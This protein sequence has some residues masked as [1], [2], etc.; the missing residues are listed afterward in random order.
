VTCVLG[1]VVDGP[2]I[3][4]DGLLLGAVRDAANVV[5]LAA[6]RSASA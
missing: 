5:D 3:I 4:P 1:T 2:P 6:V